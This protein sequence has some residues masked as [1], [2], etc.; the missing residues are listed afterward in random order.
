LDGNER[1]QVLSILE[2]LLP[3]NKSIERNYSP[4]WSVYRLEKNVKTSSKSQSLLCNLYRRDETPDFKKTSFFF[5]MFQSRQD[6]N[7]K[8]LRLFY[9]PFG[10]TKPES[11]TVKAG[12]TTKAP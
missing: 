9:I 3:N 4:L 11:K 5:G 10:K 7:G 1:L 8:Q 12:E 2:P 6:A